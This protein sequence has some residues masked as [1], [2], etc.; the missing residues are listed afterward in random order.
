MNPA[1]KFSVLVLPDPEG[2]R[3]DINSP[4][5][6]R[7]VKVGIPR[8]VRG[9]GSRIFPSRCTIDEAQDHAP[10][11]LWTYT[12]DRPNMGIGGIT[13]QKLKLAA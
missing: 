8:K 9:W 1:I 12:N 5:S 13:P 7:R 2:P 11:W 10:K 6:T 4:G 3:K